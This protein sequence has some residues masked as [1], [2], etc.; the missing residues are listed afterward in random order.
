MASSPTKRTL[1]YLRKAGWLAEVTER[2]NPHARIR[3]DL[4]GFC[5]VL[6]IKGNEVMAIQATSQSNVTARIKKILSLPSAKL[7]AD[8]ENRSI[9]VVGWRKAR[10]TG[11][12]EHSFQWVFASDFTQEAVKESAASMALCG[13]PS[14]V[15]AC[16]GA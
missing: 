9:G 15:P 1:D 8:G 13:K 2:W 10:K 12:W 3:R 5:D 16:A 7:W 11:R 14:D 6:A 4:F